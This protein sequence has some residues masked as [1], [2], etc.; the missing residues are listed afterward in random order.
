[1]NVR[2]LI[3]GLLDMAV[4]VV[5]VVFVVVLISRYSKVAYNYGYRILRKPRASEVR[6]SEFMA[7]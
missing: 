2:K 7:A 3:L 6:R 1:M 5:F 4:K